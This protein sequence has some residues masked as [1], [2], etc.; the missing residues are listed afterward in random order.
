MLDADFEEV[1]RLQQG[2]KSAYEELHKLS[3]KFLADASSPEPTTAVKAPAAAATAK[4]SAHLAPPASG[5]LGGDDASSTT[6]THSSTMRK[7]PSEAS[8]D[9]AASD[10]TNYTSSS[11]PG[12][13][14]RPLGQV[15]ADAARDASAD[16]REAVKVVVQARFAYAFCQIVSAKTGVDVTQSLGFTANEAQQEELLERVRQSRLKAEERAAKSDAQRLRD[17]SFPTTLQRAEQTHRKG[18]GDDTLHR[19]TARDVARIRN[20]LAQP[21]VADIAK[22][23]AAAAAAVAANKQQQ[24]KPDDAAN[25]KQL[26]GW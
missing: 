4:A 13:R 14:Q 26:V 3:Q 1:L 21:D 19:A 10:G 9:E 24:S 22:K 7:T 5:S 25:A 15:D 11:S 12:S 2:N 20:F 23:Y 8:E 16:L 18:V 6:T 17:A